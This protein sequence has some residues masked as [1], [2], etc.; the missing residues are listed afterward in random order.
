M[1]GVHIYHDQPRAPLGKNVDS[2]Q[3]C[4]GVAKRWFLIAVNRR[5]GHW[6]GYA[7]TGGYRLRPFAAPAG[8]QGLVKG[9][10]ITGPPLLLRLR[11]PAK[12]GT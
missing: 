8:I 3:L 10:L 11:L 12:S 5:C 9:H 2:M 7:I 1:S 4:N 6:R